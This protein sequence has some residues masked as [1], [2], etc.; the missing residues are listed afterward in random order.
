MKLRYDEIVIDIETTGLCPV[1]DEILQIAIIDVNGNTLY[2]SYIKPI[3]ATE[4]TDAEN[5]NHIS[6]DMVKD[7]PDIYAAMP[8]VNAILSQ[9]KRIIGYNHINFDLEFMRA[10][11][12]II[13]DDAELYDVMLEFAPIYGERRYDTDD[14][15]K[16]Q[17]LTV[18]AAYYGYDWRNDKAHDGEADCRATLHCYRKM[19]DKEQ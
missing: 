18:C 1:V 9:A 13:P 5:I 12:A 14:E 17:K 8:V 19:T 7:A 6:P 2:N 4:W 3:C 16:W 11:G 15:Y 10:Y